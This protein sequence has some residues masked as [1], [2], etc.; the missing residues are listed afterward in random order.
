MIMFALLFNHDLCCYYETVVSLIHEI[1][2]Q[3]RG[4]SIPPL[5]KTISQ[6]ARF[7]SPIRN[8]T[9]SLFF[10]LAYVVGLTHYQSSVLKRISSHSFPSMYNQSGQSIN[11]S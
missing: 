3:E 8:M 11:I 6:N 1:W 2:Y 5:K 7:N 9:N 4:S 10:F